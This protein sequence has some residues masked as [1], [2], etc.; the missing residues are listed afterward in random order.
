M[1]LAFSAFFFQLKSVDKMKIQQIKEKPFNE[2]SDFVYFDI[3][4]EKY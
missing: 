1:I 4:M 3:V 2:N